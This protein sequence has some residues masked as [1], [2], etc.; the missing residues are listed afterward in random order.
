MNIGEKLITSIVVTF[1]VFGAMHTVIAMDENQTIDDYKDDVLSFN[2]YGDDFNFTDQKPN[3][4]IKK[5]TYQHNDGVKQVTLTLEVYG[6][7][8]NRGKID[9]T[10]PI[11]ITSGINRVSYGFIITTSEVVYQIEYVNQTCKII[12]LDETEENITSFSVNDATL[13]INFDL[14]NADETYSEMI[15]ETQDIL[16][17][18]RSGEANIYMDM[19]L[20]DYCLTVDAGGPYEAWV[21]ESIQFEG[22]AEYHIP[23]PVENFNFSWDFGDGTTSSQKK[24]MHSYNK[25]GNYTVNLTVSDETRE[26]FWDTATVTINPDSTPPVVQIIQP[27]NG[28]YIQNRKILPLLR[29]FIFGYIKIESKALDDQS[30]VAY[31]EL[32][33]DGQLRGNFTGNSLVWNWF[34]MSF[35]IH[36]LKVI[37]Y[38]NAGNSAVDAILVWKFF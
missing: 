37:A 22:E 38:D 33:I 18:P 20:D 31:L 5:A 14:I 6:Q 36:F 8:E 29:P 2:I 24:P 30:G 32:Y 13:Q 25:A 17:N 10:D 21:G 7:I 16:F 15:A 11:D 23:R 12:Y 4:D 26:L 9:I 35:S 1:L 27:K 28:L 19:A 34:E 3:I